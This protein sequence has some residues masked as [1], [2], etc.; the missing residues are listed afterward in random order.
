MKTDK[1]EII[2][3]CDSHEVCFEIDSKR[4][5]FKGDSRSPLIVEDLEK[6]EVQ[7]AILKGAR[8]D[9]IGLAT[10]VSYFRNWIDE[11]IKFI[12]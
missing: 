6:G 9:N 5:P 12:W 1:Y 2:N 3:N 4:T 8:G 10:K 11:K 7:V